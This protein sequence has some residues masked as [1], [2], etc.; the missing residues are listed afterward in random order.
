MGPCKLHFVENEVVV[1]SLQVEFKHVLLSRNEMEDV[2]AKLGVDHSFP[3][4]SAYWNFAFS[5]C[6]IIL[7]YN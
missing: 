6:G 3:F 4:A 2:L 1:S 7:L 5:C